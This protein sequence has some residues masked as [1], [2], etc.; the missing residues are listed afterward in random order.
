MQ[1][2]ALGCLIDRDLHAMSDEIAAP[3]NG[4]IKA[5]H[6]GNERTQKICNAASKN[7]TASQVLDT[8]EPAQALQRS[9]AESEAAIRYAYSESVRIL[10]KR[11][12]NAIHSD[13]EHSTLSSSA[14]ANTASQLIRPVRSKIS[15]STL[16][17]SSRRSA[18]ISK[19]QTILTL[20]PLR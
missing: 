20:V 7:A 12:S 19:T 11:Y 9:L 17:S 14:T 3:V 10:G 15:R 5:F 8:V 2:P 18:T 13:R 16:K 6:K 1:G 4:I